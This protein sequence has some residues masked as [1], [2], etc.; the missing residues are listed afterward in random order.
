M[1]GSQEQRSFYAHDRGSHRQA[2]CMI[3]DAASFHDAALA[4]AERQAAPADDGE[5]SVIVK[6]FETGEEQCFVVHLDNG[7]ADPC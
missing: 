3:R 6:D 7:E 1:D 5:I 2:G 4:F